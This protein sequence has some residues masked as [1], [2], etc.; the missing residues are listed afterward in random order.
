MSALPPKADMCGATNNPGSLAIF[1]A[2]RRASSLLSNS[3]AD[4]RPRLIL[5]ID[6]SELLPVVVADDETM[7]RR[8]AEGSGARARCCAG[9]I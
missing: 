1:A 9:L 5:E 2:I 4:R 7:P 3:A 8:M 6:I